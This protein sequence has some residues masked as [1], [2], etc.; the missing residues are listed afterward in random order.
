M[1]YIHLH[2]PLVSLW[3]RS[4][5]NKTVVVFR[6]S[7]YW[8]VPSGGNVS[9]PFPL[10]QRWP[11]LPLALEAAAFSPLDSKWYFFKGIY[12]FFL[13]LVFFRIVLLVAR[14]RKPGYLLTCSTYLAPHYLYYRTSISFVCFPWLTSLPG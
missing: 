3:A 14:R 4:D 10:R 11:H 1:Q 7:V 6:G 8:T 5:H 9:G 2:A 13:S 12:L